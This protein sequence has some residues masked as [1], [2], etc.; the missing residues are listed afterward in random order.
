M[1]PPNNYEVR[2]KI[3]TDVVRVLEGDELGSDDPQSAPF[4]ALLRD[5][6]EVDDHVFHDPQ[7]RPSDAFWSDSEGTSIEPKAT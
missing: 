4:D 6:D 7:G 2:R 1:R 3:A 5:S